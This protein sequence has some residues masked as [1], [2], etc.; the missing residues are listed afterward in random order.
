M[1][2]VVNSWVVDPNSMRFEGRVSADAVGVVKSG[3]GVAREVVSLDGYF[4]VGSL[5]VSDLRLVGRG[6]QYLRTRCT[7]SVVGEIG[8]VAGAAFDA[9]SEAKLDELEQKRDTLLSDL[10][11]EYETEQEEIAAKRKQEEDDIAEQRRKEDE[12]REARRKKEDDE[13]LERIAAQ[14]VERQGKYDEE[15]RRVEDEADEG[16]DGIEEE[17]RKLFDEGQAKL[18]ELEEKRKVRPAWS[19]R[20]GLSCG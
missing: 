6:R 5:D 20:V 7:V 17:V 18:T 19:W 9:H 2:G 3:Q 10:K 14:D 13:F 15:T 4:R 16:L 8:G 12:E 11:L 1:C